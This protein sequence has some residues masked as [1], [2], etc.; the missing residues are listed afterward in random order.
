[1]YRLRG[2]VYHH[3]DPI[4]N[5]Y[6]RSSCLVHLAKGD[7]IP[8]VAVAKVIMFFLGQQA[9]AVLYRREREPDTHLCLWMNC[10]NN[11]LKVL[12]TRDVFH[13]RHYRA[14]DICL[15]TAHYQVVI[16]DCEPSRSLLVLCPLGHT[17]GD[18][19]GGMYANRVASIAKLV[20]RGRG[21][22]EA[23]GRRGKIRRWWQ[24]WLA[25]A[26]SKSFYG[27]R[28]LLVLRVSTAVS[29]R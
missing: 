17:E 10:F 9:E 20:K 8:V 22:G 21:G 2:K 18:V 14:Y 5:A 7:K 23:R 11:H 15:E 16:V 24:Y 28:N 13:I 3:T 1:M 26:R 4:R 12:R 6:D 19:G 25:R 27:G 29:C